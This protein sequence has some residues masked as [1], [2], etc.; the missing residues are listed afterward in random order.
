MSDKK[1]RSSRRGSRIVNADVKK[2]MVLP[3]PGTV[4]SD[5]YEL[6]EE[7]GRGG[8]G[9]VFRALD[10]ELDLSVAIKILPPELAHSKRAVTDLKREARLAMR[11]RHPGIMGLYHFADSEDIKYLVMELLSG[12][13]L[14]DKLLEEEILEIDDVQVMADELARAL[15]YAHSERV[16]HRDIKPANIFLH[17][18][19]DKEQVRL[20][21]FGIARQMREAMSRVSRQD[22][23]GTLLYMSPEQLTG[24]T[25]D[26][27]SDIYSLAAT[28]YECLAGNPPFYQGSISYQITNIA[29]TAIEGLPDGVN[30][31]LLRALAKTP[32]ERF[33]TAVEFA[34]ALTAAATATDVA[35][36][37]PAQ[38][39]DKAAKAAAAQEK[40]A[41]A[42]ATVAQEKEAAAKAA[43]AQEKEAAAKAA[44]AQE[45]EAAAKA[46]VAQEKEAAAKAAVAAEKAAAETAAAK[47]KEEAAKAAVAAETAAAETAAAKQKEEA[48][49]AAVAAETAAAETAAAKKKEAAAKAAVAAEKTPKAAK[50]CFAKM[51]S[52]LWSSICIIAV[53]LGI[54]WLLLYYFEEYVPDLPRAPRPSTRPAATGVPSQSSLKPERMPA[55]T[56][57]QPPPSP[58]TSSA[59]KPTERPATPFD[60]AIAEAISAIRDGRHM[61]ALGHFQQAETLSEKFPCD[62]GRLFEI[63]NEFISHGRFEEAIECLPRVQEHENDVGLWLELGRQAL[64]AKAYEAAITALK[65]TAHLKPDT[66]QAYHCLGL[67]AERYEN[68]HERARFYA[69]LALKHAPGNREYAKRLSV[70]KSQATAHTTPSKV[71]T[72]APRVTV[73]NTSAPS[74]IPA[75]R[76]TTRPTAPITSTLT[77]LNITILRNEAYHLKNE[78]VFY[79]PLSGGPLIKAKVS[80][81][82]RGAT[83]LHRKY[84]A[85][86]MLALG[87]YSAVF[88]CE[89][90]QAFGGMQAGN[91]R[92]QLGPFTV[93]GYNR[94]SSVDLPPFVV[95]LQ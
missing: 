70:L 65:R 55:S 73:K 84:R 81:S 47:Q 52:C 6:I 37:S 12:R 78:Q 3:G 66:H 94:T 24:K 2:T 90:K 31:A 75:T 40:E 36:S 10:G 1:K 82:G 61:D 51:W 17:L 5:R 4:L 83:K 92:H 29:P 76:P 62:Q 35:A 80:Y 25:A 39:Q 57:Q 53:L 34:Q 22:L 60:T 19:H 59:V 9:V 30:L 8:M 33:S 64:E 7:I 85:T 69:K 16:V 86:T 54:L 68:N 38:E 87:Q 14:E 20:M 13:T 79:Q 28:L 49:K 48:A 45:K 74:P 95:D 56:I 41:A 11:L 63:V 43:V 18:H 21:D 15:D 77:T 89:L 42:K 32:E 27:R 26:G 93:T 72:K 44:V 71:P 23:S 58:T 46:A 88:V 50:G 91:F 67:I